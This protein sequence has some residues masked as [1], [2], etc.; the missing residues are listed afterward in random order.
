MSGNPQIPTGAA[1]AWR[2]AIFYAALFV[3]LGVQ[4]PFL[5]VWLAAKELDAREI[6]IVLAV[7]MV[8]RLAAVPLVTHLADRRDA[9]RG[10]IIAAA[11]AAALS[12][13]LLGFAE[14]ALAIV[15]A[16]AI[17]SALST[18]L[19]P[20]ADAY[21]L[22]GLADRRSYGPV[23][24]W[25]SATFIVGSLGAGLLLD[26]IAPRHLIWLL[27]AA[28]VPLAAAACALAPLR[29]PAALAHAQTPSGRSLLR[30]PAFL[31]VIAAASLIQASHAVYYGFSALDWQA[32]GL[33]GGTIGALW[34]LGVMAEIAL[35][36]VS[37]RLA[38]SPIA[39]ILIGAV[40][41]V[42]RWAAMAFNPAFVLLPALQCLH[43][44]S[45]GATH[46]GAVA[47]VARTAPADFG[48]RA[49]GYVAVVQGLV[50]AGA[51]ALSGALYAR[52]GD[53]A[54]A[55]MAVMAGAG[56]LCALAALRLAR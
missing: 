54:Y 35:F 16:F 39:L 12:Y 2:L 53:L 50:M 9:V 17:V 40:G 44:L 15:V 5:P 6:G 33:D 21:A 13:A 30:D 55:A 51:M 42:L 22:R 10:A 20:L 36:A 19:M 3:A 37:G 18:P 25:G 43:A 47:F 4:L 41:A 56:A 48:A 49:Q 32:L 29:P 1:F 34:A 23:R 28:M 26:L 11:G 8:V 31:A 7:P 27:L 52:F 46:L 45:F 24:L 38:L 14:G